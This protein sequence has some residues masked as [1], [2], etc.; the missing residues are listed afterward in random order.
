MAYS[1]KLLYYARV[2]CWTITIAV[3]IL[4]I[5][6]KAVGDLTTICLAGWTAYGV[7][8][9]FYY[10]MA[11]SDHQIQLLKEIDSTANEKVKEIIID[12]VEEDLK[13]SII[14]KLETK[15]E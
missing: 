3:F 6:N 1:K 4:A 8:R 5:F 14:E 10:N 9:A 15:Q 2:E 12:K 13:D 7:A 11:K